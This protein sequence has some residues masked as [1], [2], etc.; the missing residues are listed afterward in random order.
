MEKVILT[1]MIMVEDGKGNVV[2]QNRKNGW[3]GWAFPGGKVELGESFINAAIREVK[4]ET[5]LD[6]EKLTLCGTKQFHTKTG[7]RYIVLLYKTSTY[8]GVL[9]SSDEGEVKWVS[10][11][12]IEKE[13]VAEDFD[14]ML[15]VFLNPSISELYYDENSLT[16]L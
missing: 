1:N 9:T 15:K 5:G 13:K 2:V 16:I 3:N 11:D 6:I 10:L 7:E 14:K 4:E 8:K 12:A